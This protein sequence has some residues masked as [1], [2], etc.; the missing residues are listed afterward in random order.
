MATIE[1]S[2]ETIQSKEV[3][4]N[5]IVLLEY[6]LLQNVQFSMQDIQHM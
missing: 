3:W 4:K 6:K 1:I 2:F 5:Q